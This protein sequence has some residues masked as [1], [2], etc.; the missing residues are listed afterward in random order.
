MRL[1]AQSDEHYLRKSA[2]RNA[3][4]RKVFVSTCPVMVLASMTLTNQ[5]RSR[6]GRNTSYVPEQEWDRSTPLDNHETVGVKNSGVHT[7]RSTAGL[8]KSG[9]GTV[10]LRAHS[11]RNKKL[12]AFFF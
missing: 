9:H 5:R 12:P 4:I 8:R 2:Y 3:Q 1:I 6:Q 10:S 11:I 7:S